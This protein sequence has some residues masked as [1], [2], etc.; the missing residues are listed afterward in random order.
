[1]HRSLRKTSRA[2][3]RAA[4]WLGAVVSLPIVA[5]AAWHFA[6]VLAAM[7]QGGRGATWT[8]GAASYVVTVAVAVLVMG[9]WAL[10]R[11]CTRSR[12]RSRTRTDDAGR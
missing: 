9:A 8:F 2:V 7:G 4:F 10:V 12:T 6:L 3:A 11:K 1:M 5:I